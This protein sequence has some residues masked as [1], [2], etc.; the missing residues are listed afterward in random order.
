M[1]IEKHGKIPIFKPTTRDRNLTID[2]PK[3]DNLNDVTTETLTPSSD[4]LTE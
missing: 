4:V 1:S 2:I 3:E